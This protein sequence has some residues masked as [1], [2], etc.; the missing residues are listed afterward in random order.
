MTIRIN[1][2]ASR[3]IDLLMLCAS[4]EE[5]LTLNDICEMMNMPKSSAFELVQTLVY[6]GMLELKDPVQKRYG[7]SL[8]AFEIG[9]AVTSNMKCPDV[10]RPFIQELNRQ[11]GSTVFLGVEDKGKI[12]YLDKSE[13]HSIIKATAKLGSRRNLHTTGLGKSLLFAYSDEKIK[14]IMGNEPYASKTPL[15]HTNYDS[16]IEDAARARARGYTIDDR[17]DNMD[18]Y[19]IGSAIYNSNGH[20]IASL[21]VASL[22]NGMAAEKEALISGL[23]KDAAMKISRK[24][25]FLGERTYIINDD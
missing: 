6:K 24:L 2:S 5:F 9:S 15:S 10:A 23:V 14:K 4:S 21:S 17:E 11:T 8:L 16:L 1:K 7:L 19:C 22:Y 12:V 18:M 3:T 25:G 13:N 20:P